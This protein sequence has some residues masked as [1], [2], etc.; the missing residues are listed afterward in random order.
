MSSMKGVLSFYLPSYP[1]MLIYMLQSTEYQVEPYLKWYWRTVDFRSVMKRRTLQKT[2]A[3]KALLL[4]LRL[5]MAIQVAVGIWFV[6]HWY[7]YESPGTWQ[8]GLA[9][10]VSYPIIWAHLITVP[11]ILGRFFIVLPKEKWLIHKSKKIFANHPGVK[12]AV[13]GS[14]GKTTMKEL[15]GTVLSEGKNVAITPANKNV[16]SS[17]AVFAKNLKGDEDILIIEFGEGR[18]GDVKRFT[19]TIKPDIGVITGIAPAHLDHYPNIKA[20]AD[21]IYSLATYLGDKNIYVNIDSEFPRNFK[22]DTHIGYGEH[23][24]GEWK[25]YEAKVEVTGISFRLWKGKR[26]LD[27][28]SGLLGRHQI[29]PLSAVA[30]IAHEL[31]LKKEEIESGVAKTNAF[32]HRMQPR[33]IGNAWVIDDTYNGN[34]DGIQAGL[35]LLKELP[36]K[37]KIYVTPGLVD[38]GVETERVHWKM[39][40]LIAETKP[41]KVVLMDNSVTDFILEG[42]AK[43]D[44]KENKVE[45]IED[46][47]E[48]YTNLSHFVAAGDLVLMQN[49]WTDNYS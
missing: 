40:K 30:V 47:L 11:L 32:E 43:N 6:W 27:L 2:F 33:N 9:L 1:K 10:L 19:E 45:I 44:Y 17:H 49:D 25:A 26:I 8:F 23:G 4:A 37:R 21:D 35:K 22:K 7:V 36:A 14:Y 5:G 12:I 18:P 15:L 41:D 16:A 48:F 46:P 34:I 3:A 20:A 28:T 29:G 38:Q 42:L 39:G 31:G 13:A 24:A